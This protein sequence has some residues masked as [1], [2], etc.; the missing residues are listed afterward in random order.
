MREYVVAIGPNAIDEYYLCDNWPKIGEKCFMEYMKAVPGGMIPNAASV[1]AG[2]GL[3][4]YSLDTLGNDEYTVVIL[5]DLKKNGVKTEYI[6]ISREIKNT[7]THIIL[8][9]NERTIFIVLNKKPKVNIDE[10]KR[11]LLLN[12]SYIY[13]TVNDM[14]NVDGSIDLIEQL[15]RKGVKIFFDVESESFE[16][17]EQDSFYFENAKVLVFNEGGFEKYKAGRSQEEVDKS[18]F[19]K[20]V[21]IIVTT[22]GAKGCI[23][24]TPDWTKTFPGIKVE[25]KDPTGAGDTFNSTFL[26][27]LLQGWSIDKIAKYAN[28]AAARSIMYFGPKGGIAPIKEIEE[29]IQKYEKEGE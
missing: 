4:V 8:S 26:Y 15:K 19:S 14:K 10:R 20:G 1:M 29:F 11:D 18:L 9:D 16:D 28:Y 25:V 6:D 2:Y 5:D 7:K 24:R 17:A 21:E 13:S 27:G 12:A 23:V 3:E 22:L